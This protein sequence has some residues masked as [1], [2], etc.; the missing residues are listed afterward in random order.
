MAAGQSR[1]TVDLRFLPKH[2]HD[3]G[4][5]RMREELQ[6]A[7]DAI[8][9]D[10][11]DAVVLGYGL[12]SGGTAGLV[13]SHT[14]LVIPRVHDCLGLFFGGHAQ[15]SRYYFDHPGTYYLTTGWLERGGIESLMQGGTGLQQCGLCAESASWAET[16]GEDNAAY[17]ADVLGAPAGYS[18]LA[19]IEVG[20]EPDEGF[21]KQAKQMADAKGWTFDLIQG[22]MLM[23]H[24]LV[25]C[26]WNPDQFLVVP[27]GSTAKHSYDDSVLQ[28][29]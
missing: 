18:H 26:D 21:A 17:L 20:I 7:L 25:A 23:F 14:P 29:S 2:L 28:L 15:Y 27:P 5:G 10:T 13:C 6:G 4:G 22:S 24:G 9:P 16:Y 1:H 11:Y 3:L 8:A 19:F 12:C